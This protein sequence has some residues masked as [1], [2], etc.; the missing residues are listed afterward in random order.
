MHRVILDID[1]TETAELPIIS[2]IKGL[3]KQ[4]QKYFRDNFKS[5]LFYIA[6]NFGRKLPLFYSWILASL[7]YYCF[8]FA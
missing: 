2:I 5:H 4:N 3:E 7:G 1:M 6:D 8:A